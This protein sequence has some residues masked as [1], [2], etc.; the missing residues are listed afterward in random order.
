MVGWFLQFHGQRF[1]NALISDKHIK[2]LIVKWMG[3][4]V[5]PVMNSAPDILDNKERGLNVVGWVMVS[6]GNSTVNSFQNNHRLI[7]F[8]R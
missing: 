7:I 5:G 2:K 1:F 6:G 3:W 4:L 8:A